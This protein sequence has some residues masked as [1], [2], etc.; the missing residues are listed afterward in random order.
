M[1]SV[2]KD[3]RNAA[4]VADSWSNM[5]NYSKAAVN[6]T[7][8]QLDWL[9]PAPPANF[10]I[11]LWKMSGPAVTNQASTMVVTF[12]TGGTTVATN[13]TTVGRMS[14]AVT[15]SAAFTL[16]LVASA[17]PAAGTPLAMGGRGQALHIHGVCTS[18][19]A[20]IAELTYSLVYDAS[21]PISA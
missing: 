17:Q 15:V 8:S 1:S 7:T 13:T 19:T 10:R 18:A 9:I 21:D 14:A 3:V 20:C 12:L 4:V 11:K 5:Q 6:T 2:Q 16:P